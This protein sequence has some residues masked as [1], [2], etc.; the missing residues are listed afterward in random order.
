MDHLRRLV[1]N[2]EVPDQPLLF[3]SATQILLADERKVIA[4]AFRKAFA[5]LRSSGSKSDLFVEEVDIAL[6]EL[7]PFDASNRV[8]TLPNVVGKVWA[9]PN[10]LPAYFAGFHFLANVR[11][12]PQAA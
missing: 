7:T 4:P 11:V 8:S 12:L 5:P 6:I 2:G 1:G 9:V 10:S 3:K